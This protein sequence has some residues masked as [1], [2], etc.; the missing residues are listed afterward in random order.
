[1][2][3]V[4]QQ[5]TDAVRARCVTC[6]EPA[7]LL[8]QRLSAQQW[9]AEIEKMERWGAQVSDEEKI[10]IASYLVMIAGPNNTSFTPRVVAPVRG[11][12]GR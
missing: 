1:M 8:Q 12:D 7:M 3:L 6:H 5:G 4:N 10:R 11:S 2:S 9:M